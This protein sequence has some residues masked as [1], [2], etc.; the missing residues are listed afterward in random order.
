LF[1]QLHANRS[2]RAALQSVT[3]SFD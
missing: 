3:L 1:T 2:I